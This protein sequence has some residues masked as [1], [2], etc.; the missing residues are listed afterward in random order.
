MA[1]GS[2]RGEYRLGVGKPAK[3]TYPIAAVAPAAKL[4]NGQEI[5]F[6][7]LQPISRRHRDDG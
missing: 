3:P 6:G 4:T 5:L 2:K 7:D 1:D